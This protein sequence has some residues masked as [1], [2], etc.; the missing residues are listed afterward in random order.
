MAFFVLHLSTISLI[1]EA[2]VCNDV[3]G[4]VF[5]PSYADPLKHIHTVFDWKCISASLNIKVYKDSYAQIDP[6]VFD[7]HP[8]GSMMNTRLFPGNFLPR[9]NKFVPWK[10]WEFVPSN[11]L[12]VKFFFWTYFTLLKYKTYFGENYLISTAASLLR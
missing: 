12:K 7:W 6:V 4:K 1:V 3:L 10:I 9:S 5:S 2:N 8:L 11:C